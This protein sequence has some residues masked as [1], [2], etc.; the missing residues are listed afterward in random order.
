MQKPTLLVLAAGMGSRYGGLKQ[1]DPMGPNGETILDYSLHDAIRSG[2]GKVVFVIREE[3]AEAFRERIGAQIEDR[4]E[5]AYAFQRLDDL[6]PG[7][8]V[9]EKRTKPWGTAHAVYAARHVVSEPC[10]VINADDFYG[11]DAYQKAASFLSGAGEG[12]GSY[13]L[14]GYYLE[15]TLSDHGGVNRGVATHRDGYLEHVE[16][17]VDIRPRE[18]GQISGTAPDGASRVLGGSTLVSMNFWGFTP[19]FFRKLEAIFHGFLE[20]GGDLANRECYIPSVI[21]ALL[22]AKLAECKVI[23]SEG[24]WFGVTYPE[25][26]PAVMQKVTSLVAAGAYPTPLS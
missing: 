13:C 11:R 20:E 10:A 17:V 25:D 15:N 21:D 7:F 9:P 26:K 1:L 12:S 19:D 5:V 2:F 24:S 18:G 23:A 8:R 22:K 3:F 14:V 6:P 4:V 16:E